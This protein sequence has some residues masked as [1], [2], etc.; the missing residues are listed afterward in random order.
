MRTGIFKST[1]SLVL[2]ASLVL[3]GLASAQNY[4]FN[5]DGLKPGEIRQQLNKLKK[6]CEARGG[7]AP[8]P[9]VD[10]AVIAT[11]EVP[12]GKAKKEE[13]A[14]AADKAAE[15][16]AAPANDPGAL[17]KPKNQQAAKDEA[18]TPK[19]KPAPA[20]DKAAEAPK[21]KPK[22][23]PEAAAEAPSAEPAP[24]AAEAPKAEPA[25]KAAEATDPGQLIKPKPQQQ[26]V[27][28]PAPKAEE[29]AR[30]AQPTPEPKPKPKAQQQAA[31]APAT[32]PK[33][34]DDSGSQAA[35]PQAAPEPAQQN[36]VVTPGDIAQRLRGQEQ[37]D[38]AATPRP[39]S[40]A[41]ADAVA[42]NRGEPSAA[43]AAAN[44]DDPG[45]AEV[46]EEEVTADDVRRSDQ[47]FGT[48][49]GATPPAQ[50]QQARDDDDDDKGLSNFEKAAIVGLGAVAL[51]QILGRN[52]NVVENTGD[53]V[54]IEE[55]GQYRVLRNDDVLLRRPGSDVKTYRYDDGSTRSVVT[56]DDGNVVET[57][58]AADG[59]VLRRTR[60]LPNGETVVLFD[61]TQQVEDVAVNEL[62][63]VTN[64]RQRVNFQQVDEYDLAAALAAQQ[65]E[66]VNR[67]FSLNQIRNIDAVRH[68]VPEVSV[69]AINFETGSAAI[70][71]EEAQALAAL[72]NA[73]TQIIT[74]SPGE[75][76]LIEGHT[77]AVGKES[78]NLA[79][80]DR[81]AE[82]VAL[83]LT[84]YFNVPPE[85]MV[86]QGYG[87]GDLAVP[88][89]S[90]ERANRR[91][92]VRRITP[93]LQGNS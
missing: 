35:A 61:D 88:T 38:Q 42:R 89:E 70:R 15:A 56:Y 84:E 27:Q 30:Q 3:P 5:T 21:P 68:L 28:E 82:S 6:L 25:P 81:R 65:V 39:D 80:S 33:A 36:G 59:R 83:A 57:I 24:E 43:A 10:C 20:A 66:G 69:S 91:A 54:V 29:P 87:E 72:G 63:Q 73:M 22:P 86:L 58:K 31:E 14:A 4:G 40:Q 93:L 62:P 71:P 45:E 60:T 8:L 16:P 92:A 79:L 55:D 48:R 12:N 78:Y 64:D 19:P 1:T 76:F 34:R 2:A 46:Q 67:T 85:N 18:A 26:A 11:A 13:A 90:A 9:G 50:Q 47:D 17:I 51:S 44:S 53:R 52:A 49:I 37:G 77:D 32:T 23:K 41:Q 7:N 74:E 75:V